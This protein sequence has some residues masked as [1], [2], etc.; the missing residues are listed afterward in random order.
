VDV[1]GVILKCKQVR[2]TFDNAVLWFNDQFLFGEKSNETYNKTDPSDSDVMGAVPQDN[3]YVKRNGETGRYGGC[4]TPDGFAHAIGTD[5]P[6]GVG[7]DDGAAPDA[8]TC[9]SYSHDREE[10]SADEEVCADPPSDNMDVMRTLIDLDNRCRGCIFEYQSSFFISDPNYAV[11]KQDVS[12]IVDKL[13]YPVSVLGNLFQEGEDNVGN[14]GDCTSDNGTVAAV[15]YS[16]PRDEYPHHDRCSGDAGENNHRCTEDDCR[17][18]DQRKRPEEGPAANDTLVEPLFS[19][20][21]QVDRGRDREP[22]LDRAPWE[23]KNGAGPVFGMPIAQSEAEE[24]FVPCQSDR[25]TPDYECAVQYNF[26]LAVDFGAF[27]ANE[28]TEDGAKHGEDR[29][30]QPKARDGN[31]HPHNTEE[32]GAGPNHEHDTVSLDIFFHERAPFFVMDNP[33]WD[34]FGSPPAVDDECAQPAGDVSSEEREQAIRDRTPI[35][36]DTEMDQDTHEHDGSET[37]S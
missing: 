8:E 33:Y 23:Y 31:S 13:V 15:P 6:Y 26:L 36:C 24:G 10:A 3:N 19:V 29:F 37:I 14:D 27:D 25:W 2:Q 20:H 16:D 34:E 4:Y 12:W 35:V 22:F 21:L 11:T 28:T 30:P 17:S 9:R 32:V 1:V 5:D 7:T 18:A